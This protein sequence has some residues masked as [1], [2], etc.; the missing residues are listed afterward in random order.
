MDQH[1]KT[2]RQQC[3]NIAWHD[4]RDSVVVARERNE[5]NIVSGAPGLANVPRGHGARPFNAHHATLHGLL[6]HTAALH[7][8]TSAQPQLLHNTAAPALISQ[9][10]LPNPL[11]LADTN[12]DLQ[13]CASLPAREVGLQLKDRQ[14][15][16][17]NSWNAQGAPIKNCSHDG[18]NFL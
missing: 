9:H 17:T 18:R 13:Q 6:K 15:A 7:T 3:R 2:I 5:R 16:E 11:S 10:A 1:T 12:S 4:Q 8:A 14:K